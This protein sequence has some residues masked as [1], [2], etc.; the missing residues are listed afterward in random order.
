MVYVVCRYSFL[1][2]EKC[3]LSVSRKQIFYAAIRVSVPAQDLLRSESFSLSPECQK[4][5]KN[6]L[7]SAYSENGVSHVSQIWPTECLL[8]HKKMPQS[9]KEIKARKSES[10]NFPYQSSFC[11]GPHPIWSCMYI[12]LLVP[13]RVF[14]FK[15]QRKDL[16]VYSSRVLLVLSFGDPLIFTGNK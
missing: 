6:I 14:F 2:T 15:P 13:F 7:H 12:I 10:C 11:G 3:V 8:I 5:P 4:L 9:I 1:S 16:F